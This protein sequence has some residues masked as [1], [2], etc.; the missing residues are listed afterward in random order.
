M[1]GLYKKSYANNKKIRK[2][3]LQTLDIIIAS[4]VYLETGPIR[5]KVNKLTNHQMVLI[6]MH[7]AET[8]TFDYYRDI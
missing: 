6:Q 4:E 2:I 5:T 3:G 8:D 7:V 1:E